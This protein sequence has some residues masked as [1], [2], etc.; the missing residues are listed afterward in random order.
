MGRR[1]FL[2][3]LACGSALPLL[4]CRD[5]AGP[6]WDIPGR[7]VN[8]G[9]PRGHLLRQRRSPGSFLPPEEP[10]FDAVVIGGGI[11]G[12]CAA[13]KLERAGVQRFVLLE[14]EDELGGTSISGCSG[15]TPFPWAAHYVNIPPPEAGCVHEVLG[16]LGVIEG[17]D[18]AGRPRVAPGCL[19]R[20]PHERLWTGGRWVEELDPFADASAAQ[21]KVLQAFHDEMLRWTLYR[22]RDGRRAFAL[23][24]RYSTR[25]EGVLA[26]DGISMEAYLRAQGWRSRELDWLVDYACRDDY[27]GRAAGVSAWAGIH[28]WACRCYDPRVRDE[29]PP[30]TLTWPEGN[31]FLVQGLLARLQ[32]GRCRTGC[33]VLQVEATQT[34][35]TVRYLDTVHGAARALRSRTAVFAGKLHT[36]PYVVA[37]LPPPQHRALSGLQYTPWLVAALRLSSLPAEEGVPMAW[38]N[39]LQD[40]PSLGYVRADHQRPSQAGPAVLVYYRPFVE[41]PDEGRAALLRRPH[42]HCVQEIMADLVRAHPDLASHVEQI[43]VYRWGHAMLRPLPGLLWGPQSRWREHPLGAL[44]FASSDAPGLPL[45]EEAVFAGVRAAEQCLACL[46]VGHRTSLEGLGGV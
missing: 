40:S 2:R 18:A 35:V 13:W 8:P 19:L 41:E 1:P 24:L 11:S 45:F 39:V 16:D 17:Y 42:A 37:G 43:D 5:G 46:G 4:A 20:W 29:Y 23:P 26:L 28:Y 27:G 44:F 21:R 30:D 22:G 6:V 25:E 36:A 12:L 31:A 14:L 38:D 34:E 9:T 15:S 10:L 32:P 3:L 7:I 33:V